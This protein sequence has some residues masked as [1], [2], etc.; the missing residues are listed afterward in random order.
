[1]TTKCQI[2]ALTRGQGRELVRMVRV[3][4]IRGGGLRCGCRRTRGRTGPALPTRLLER[5]GGVSTVERARRAWIAQGP[6]PDRVQLPRRQA[7]RHHFHVNAVLAALTWAWLE[8]C[9]AVD[10]ALAR[11]SM[12]NLKLSAFLP[13][14]VARLFAATQPNPR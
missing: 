7:A 13:L 14:V 6:F 5:L 3:K 8:L 2:V 11:I 4:R 12:V 10:R 1:M 9:H